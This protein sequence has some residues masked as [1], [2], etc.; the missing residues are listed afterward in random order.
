MKILFFIF[1]FFEIFKSVFAS[2]E[3]APPSY[4]FRINNKRQQAYFV[5]FETATYNI[6]FDIEK[7]ETRVYSEI[8]FNS[9]AQGFPIFNL[10]DEPT[11]L[12]LDGEKTTSQKIDLKNGQ[13]SERI[14]LTSVAEGEHTLNLEHTI[15][16]IFVKPVFGEGT[17]NSGFFMHDFSG[18][19][20]Q[21]YLPTTYEFSQYEMTFN[22]QVIGSTTS[23]AIFSNGKAT[24]IS[25]NTWQVKFP[26]YYNTSSVFFHIL[27]NKDVITKDFIVVANGK[28]IP[29]MLYKK[30]ESPDDLESIATNLEAD[31]KEFTERFGEYPHEKFLA[32]VSE[33]DENSGMEYTAA[34]IA[35]K[36]SMKHELAHSYFGRGIMPAD[37]NSAWI[38]EALATYAA[39]SG[40]GNAEPSKV[41][42]SN[43]ANRGPFCTTTDAHGYIEGINYLT[44]L[45]LRLEHGD[46]PWMSL[47]G[48]LKHWSQLRMHQ[49]ITTETFKEDLELF[50][51]INLT[52]EFNIYVYGKSIPK[53][54]NKE[55]I[56]SLSFKSK[57]ERFQLQL[58]Q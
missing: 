23:H 32:Y 13:N 25:E 33:T 12:I 1:F 30:I 53:A 24:Q 29:V 41:K 27:P 15:S 22:V 45:G 39:K 34:T 38:D 54:L 10:A 21:S 28:S 8:K 43:M 17:I 16:G 9:Y 36:D 26:K 4:D 19:F 2:P 49:T 57:F 44:N 47:E 50:Y 31:I 35:D 37:G 14:L 52:K 46:D 56:K 20:L 48:F 11:N 7:K 5:N 42:P 40:G 51:G 55:S 6:T 58:L 18:S 3:M